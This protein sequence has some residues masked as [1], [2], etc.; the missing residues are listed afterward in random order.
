MNTI[1]LI[2]NLSVKH[3]ITSGR[4]EMIISIVVERIVEKLKKEGELRI[5]NFGTFRILQK[6]PDVS[7]YMKLNEPVQLAKN[8]MRFEPDRVF[9]ETINSQ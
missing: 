7:S 1:D 2:N 5:T 8:M 6:Q 3:D 4:A 9:V